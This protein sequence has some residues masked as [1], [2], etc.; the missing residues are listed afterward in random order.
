MLPLLKS[1]TCSERWHRGH[2]PENSKM[3]SKD[4]CF[5]HH[6]APRKTWQSVRHPRKV[7]SFEVELVPPK[8]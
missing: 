1:T 3:V 7:N 4:S 5:S 8:S 6:L 2:H